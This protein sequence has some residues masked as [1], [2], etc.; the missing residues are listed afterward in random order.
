MEKSKKDIDILLS[1]ATTRK[2]SKLSEQIVYEIL[3]KLCEYGITIKELAEAHDINFQTISSVLK[4]K[5][6]KKSVSKLTNE[7]KQQIIHN[8][9][10]YN[11]PNKQN[12]QDI[13]IALWYGEL[14]CAEIL[15]KYNISIGYLTDISNGTTRWLKNESIGWLESYNELTDAQQMRIQINFEKTNVKTRSILSFDEIEEVVRLSTNGISLLEISKQFNVKCKRL[16]NIIKKATET[17]V[18]ENI[19]I[20]ISK[21]ALKNCHEDYNMSALG[22][23]PQLFEDYMENKGYSY[24]SELSSFVWNRY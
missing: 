17:P 21:R 1:S 8:V 5:T 14:T 16:K 9:D 3:L 12:V 23:S 15:K 4:G 10:N 20:I 7:Q 24:D 18:D 6:F 19:P 13:I 22:G 11:N 2:N